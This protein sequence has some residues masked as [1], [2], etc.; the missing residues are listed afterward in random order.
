VVEMESVHKHRDRVSFHLQLICTR[1]STR[2][3]YR[4]C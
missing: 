3:P 4:T 1:S 2:S